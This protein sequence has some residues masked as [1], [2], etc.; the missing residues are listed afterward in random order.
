MRKELRKEVNGSTGTCETVEQRQLP[1]STT[2]NVKIGQ[3][4]VELSLRNFAF[5][6]SQDLQGDEKKNIYIYI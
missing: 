6:F 3:F 2:W 1:C 4:I 5:L